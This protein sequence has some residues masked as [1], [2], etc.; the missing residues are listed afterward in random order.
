MAEPPANLRFRLYRTARLLVWGLRRRLPAALVP[1]RLDLGPSFSIGITTYG[2]RYEPYFRPLYRSLSRLF[3][4]VN[5]IVAVNGHGPAD[6][7]A[8]FLQRFEAEICRGAPEHHRFL[9]HD[10][11]HGLTTLWNG[12]L[13]AAPADRPLLILNDDLRVHA[14]LRRW[15]EAFCWSAVGLDLINSS[16]SHFIL[17][18][19]TLARVGAFDPGF[20]GIGFEDMDYT[21]RAG[22]AGVSIANHLCGYLRHEDDKPQTTSF[23]GQSGRIWGKY[24]SANQ[25]HFADQWE[26]CEPQEGVYIKQLRHHV[27]ARRPVTAFAVPPL[28]LATWPGSPLYPDRP[29]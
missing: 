6:E 8:A 3:P 2:P 13:A 16:W 14:W 1:P 17:A 11:A 24:T 29:A 4:E 22:L 26:R 15:A 12:L 25:E 5:L 7:H 19:A 27:R 28:P 23:D 20:P 21:A 9:L 10:R 18:P